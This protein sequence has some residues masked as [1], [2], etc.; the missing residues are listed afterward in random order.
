[1]RQKFISTTCQNKTRR[2]DK[3]FIAYIKGN[4]RLIRMDDF[5]VFKK[6]CLDFKRKTKQKLNLPF[7][8]ACAV[9]ITIKR[10]L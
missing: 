6:I 4:F 10:V 2:Q 3:R 8:D 9:M 1:M 5:E 7:V